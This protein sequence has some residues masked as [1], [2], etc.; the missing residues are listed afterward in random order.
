[1]FPIGVTLYTFGSSASFGRIDP[2]TPWFGREIAYAKDDVLQS[3]SGYLDIGATTRPP[4]DIRAAFLTPDARS[5][6]LD[7]LGTMDLLSNTRSE[8]DYA[9]LI[10]ALPFDIPGGIYYGVACTFEWRP[11]P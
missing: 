4:M 11:A 1:M 2:D 9:V 10:K 5:D 8:T 7:R 6:M 3:G